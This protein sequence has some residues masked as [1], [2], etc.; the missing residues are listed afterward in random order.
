MKSAIKEIKYLIEDLKKERETLISR[1][2]TYSHGQWDVRRGYDI[3]IRQVEG[4]LQDLGVVFEKPA[5]DE[6]E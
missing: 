6:F 4:D 3:R 1:R 5:Y 2:D